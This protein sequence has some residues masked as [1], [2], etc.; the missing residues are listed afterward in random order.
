MKK[1]IQPTI[2]I[3]LGN[4]RPFIYYWQWFCFSNGSKVLE[5]GRTTAGI[6]D[7]LFFDN[8]EIPPVS[9]H[10]PGPFIKTLTQPQVQPH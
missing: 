10:K 2:I 9:S 8:I 3:L 4:R 1:I 5:T 6:N 7:Y